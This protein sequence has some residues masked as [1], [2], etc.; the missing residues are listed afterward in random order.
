MADWYETFFGED[1]VQGWTFLERPERLRNEAEGAVSLLAL[2]P[3]ARLLDVPCG[4]G[5]LAG[6]LAERGYAVTGLDLSAEHLERARQ[7]AP[8]AVLVQGDMRRLPFDDAAFDGVL[9]YFTSFGYFSHAENLQVLAEFHRVLRPGGRLVLESHH[10]DSVATTFQAQSWA[11][12]A[13]G[14]LMLKERRFDRATDRLEVE[15]T[16]LDGDTSRRTRF[17]A[18]L[19]GV[20]ELSRMAGSVGFEVERVA[21]V[22]DEGLVGEFAGVPPRFALVARR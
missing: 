12:L 5:R 20:G 7:R 17:D 9:N 1:Y 21:G 4:W 16:C 11:H 13:N 19:Y 14:V 18:L 10:R 6:L 15:V 22:T 8:G 2:P 3:G